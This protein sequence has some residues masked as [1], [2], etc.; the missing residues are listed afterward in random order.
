MFL[1]SSVDLRPIAPALLPVALKIEKGSPGLHVLAARQFR[2]P[3]QQQKISVRIEYYRKLNLLEKFILRASSEI[4]PAP[5]L[6]EVANVLGLDPI[7]IESVLNDLSDRKNI[8]TS[9]D[10]LRVT[11]E[12]KKTLS[13]ETITEDPAYEAWYYLQ[14]TILGTIAF[15]RQ[16]LDVM[17]EELA[18]LED[19]NTYVAR[20]LEQFPAFDINPV[21][22]QAQLQEWGLDAHDPDMGRFV[23]Q[24][25]PSAPAELR[26]R[27]VAV[28][29]LYDTLKEN[30][31]ASI[32]FQVRSE[33]ESVPLVGEWLESQLRAQNLSLKTLCGLTDE[34]L[35]REEE[36]IQPVESVVERRLDEIRHQAA[37]QLRLQVKG[38][39][40]EKEAGTATQ[41]RDV[42]IHHAF[43][44]ALKSAREQIIIYSPWM[45]AQVVD[46]AFLSLLED[47]V[48]RGVHVLIGYGIGRDKRREDRPVPPALIQR[49][50]AIQTA[51]GTPG[52]I[53]E[54]LGNSHAKEIVIDQKIHLSGSH[55]WLS[56][57]GDRFPRGE[58]V[59]QVTIPGEVEKAYNHLAQRFIERAQALWHHAS[60]EER[61]LALCI[62]G[63]LGHEQEA[64]DWIR[65]DKCYQLVPFWMALA[66][67]A[68]SAN[69]KERIVAPL[70][71]LIS[72]CNAKAQLPDPL[73]NEIGVAL[74]GVFKRIA[75]PG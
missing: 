11:E 58:T 51:E 3:V 71:E 4:S 36:E 60:D 25:A 28:F 38:Q 40:L 67:Q 64:A 6:K 29:V 20:D 45:N 7:F 9:D 2:Y 23:K 63:Y 24:M 55:N 68:I 33:D 34:M 57:R 44:K 49:M 12:G 1:V 42:E 22:Q 52:I 8:T 66:H 30:T 18:Q 35:A 72:L 50:S 37:S 19:L 70:H 74:Q 48:K 62:L 69:H 5:S 31:D 59:Y 47:R 56:Y 14:D 39:E 15:T 32:T 61:K 17:D 41:L 54:W 13:S 75:R 26:W 53:A 27:P 16:P 46:D 73:L 65:R 21:E 43:L 10:R